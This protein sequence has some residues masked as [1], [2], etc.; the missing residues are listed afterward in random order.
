MSASSFLPSRE[1]RPSRSLL[2]PSRKGQI[3]DDC[4]SLEDAS[5]LNHFLC[6]ETFLLQSQESAENKSIQNADALL[7]AARYDSFEVVKVMCINHF[8]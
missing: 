6:A 2:L 7:T 3:F 4:N 1:R 5:R 8:W